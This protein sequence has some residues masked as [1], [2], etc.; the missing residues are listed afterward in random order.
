MDSIVQDLMKQVATGDNLAAISQSVEGDSTAVQSALGMAMPLIMSSMADTASKP[1]GVDTLMG[2]V[3]QLGGANPAENV[4]G[5]LGSPQAAGGAG[6]VSALLG[7]QMGG[8]QNAIAQKTGLP[9]A[10]VGQILAIAVPVVVGQV[11]KMFAGSGMD[12]NA[13]SG[14]LGDQSAAA[15]ESAPEIAAIAQQVMSGQT[16]SAGG[17]MG[18]LKKFLK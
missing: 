14:L 8:I 2:M 18:I 11:G 13:L 12:K 3:S 6:M 15:M 4:N 17:V 5:F 7:S 16:P 10:I 9:P 1:G